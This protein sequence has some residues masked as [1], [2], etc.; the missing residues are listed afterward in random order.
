MNGEIGTKINFQSILSRYLCRRERIKIFNRNKKA[1]GK[2]VR[3][4]ME[5]YGIATDFPFSHTF[6]ASQFP[7]M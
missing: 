7:N 4:D 3:E 2:R 6:I 5:I 1:I